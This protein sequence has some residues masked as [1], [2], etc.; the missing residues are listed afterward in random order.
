[1]SDESKPAEV[2]AVWLQQSPINIDTTRAIA[3]TFPPDYL[4]I[5]YTNEPITGRFENHD[6]FFESK[7]PTLLFDG[8][9]CVLQRIHIHARSEHRVD[10]ADHDF[11]AHLVHSITGADGGSKNLVIGVFFLEKAGAKAPESLRKLNEKLKSMRAGQKDEKPDTVNPMHFLPEKPEDREK[12]FRYE[13]SLTTSPFTEAVSWLV[14]ATPIA[15][16]TG[17]LEDLKREAQHT[18]RSLQCLNRRFVLKNTPAKK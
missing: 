8:K 18:A 7:H 12:W 13:G 9:H 10:L 16:G 11:E 17:E 14:M 5:D 2:Q 4:R 3:A 1:M 6:F 15:V